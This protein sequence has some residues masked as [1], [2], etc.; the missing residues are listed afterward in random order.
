MTTQWDHQDGPRHDYL[1][2]TA[3]DVVLGHDFGAEQSD[4]AWSCS[5][6]AFLA[7]WQHD[8]IRSTFGEA[9]LA[10]AIEAVKARRAG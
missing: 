10:E 9:V 5:H 3:R 2:V 4:S 6:E 1:Y 7:G 8:E